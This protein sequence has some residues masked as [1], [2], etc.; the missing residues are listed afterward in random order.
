MR[1][2]TLSVTNPPPSLESLAGLYG[3]MDSLSFTDGE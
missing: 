1:G 2:M 3:V